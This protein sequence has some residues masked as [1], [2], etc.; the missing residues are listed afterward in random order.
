[1]ADPS[2]SILG[3]IEARRGH[4]L[5]ESGLHGGLWLDLDQLFVRPATLKPF[6]MTLAELLRPFNVDAVCGPMLGGAFVA[7]MMAGEL[8]CEFWFTHKTPTTTSAAELYSARYHLPPPL[9][10]RVRGKRVAIVDDAMSAGSS[11]RATY[12]ALKEC[13]A[14]VAV[15][16]ALLV[17]GVRGLDFFEQEGVPVVSVASDAYD[18]WSPADCPACR[19]GMPLERLSA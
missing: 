13:G 18:F 14:Q 4:F 6:I 19:A 1:M 11:L 16:G 7:Q 2:T 10:Q 5:L 17:L 9:A 3:L 15:V 12:T 8:A